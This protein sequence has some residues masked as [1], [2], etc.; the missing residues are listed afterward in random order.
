MFALSTCFINVYAKGNSIDMSRA[1]TMIGPVD[2]V[3]EANVNI[4]LKIKPLKAGEDRI[5]IIQSPGGRVDI[6]KNIIKE[7][8]NEKRNHH[9]LVCIVNSFAHSMAF[10]IYSH[11]DYRIATKD[12]KMI[13]HMIALGGAPDRLTAKNMRKYAD[14][15]DHMDEEF[16]AYNAKAMHLPL[17]VYRAAA[18]AEKAWNTNE[19]TFIGYVDEVIDSL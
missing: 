8:E 11:C 18:D 6:G 9:K 1:I 2:E 10:N 13:A 17:M 12:A 5:L 4:Q 7:L 16:N 14:Y 3:M 19:L 15:L